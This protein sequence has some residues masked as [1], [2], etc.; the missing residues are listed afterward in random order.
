MNKVPSLDPDR[1]PEE[2][3]GTR[4]LFAGAD[5][6]DLTIT[7]KPEY[8]VP[9]G[10]EK[11]ALPAESV[12]EPIR[13]P[14][15]PAFS[16]N[17]PSDIP[18]YR[19]RVERFA[20]RAYAEHPKAGAALEAQLYHSLAHALPPICPVKTVPLGLPLPGDPLRKEV[21]LTVIPEDILQQAN[22]HLRAWEAWAQAHCSQAFR[23]AFPPPVSTE[24]LWGQL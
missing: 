16:R 5:G 3:Q 10:L 17:R 7:L 23:D 19:L 13:Q 21:Q 4:L 18:V 20:D 9:P 22:A 14:A 12:P 2:P 8:T 1:S 15:Q 11:Y 6:T 24:Q